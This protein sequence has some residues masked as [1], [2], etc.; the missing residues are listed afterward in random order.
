MVLEHQ[1]RVHNLITRAGFEARSAIFQD[2]AISRVLDRDPNYRSD[3]TLRRIERAGTEL[4][5]ALF[6]SDEFP[7]NSEVV[8]TS[9]FSEQF[10]A[11]GPHSKSGKSLYQLDLERR[12]FRYPLSYL[13]YTPEFN[14][15]PVA[16]LEVVKAQASLRLKEGATPDK[17]SP[18]TEDARVA[19]LEILR[20]T[21]PDF[22]AK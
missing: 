20:E 15:L 2:E 22:L 16:I 21:K 5:E 13:I 12:L 10:S 3:S 7:L 19:I 18:L 14:A 4:A 8:G 9:R 17:L 1:A 6:Y 11:R